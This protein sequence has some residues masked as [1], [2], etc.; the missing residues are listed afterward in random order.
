MSER[1]LGKVFS[2]VPGSRLLVQRSNYHHTNA[3][4][5]LASRGSLSKY[6]GRWLFF[7]LDSKVMKGDFEVKNQTQSFQPYI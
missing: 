7:D 5:L 2:L 3:L 1:I 6:D 4:L